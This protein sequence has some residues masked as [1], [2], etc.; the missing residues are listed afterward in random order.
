[1]KRHS[2]M[3]IEIHAH[4][5]CRGS[6][7]SK[8]KLS[9][10]RALSVVNYLEQHGIK[11]ARVQYKGLGSSQPKV[12]CPDCISCTEKQHALNRIFEFKVLHL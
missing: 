3:V 2:T 6:E 11:R 5:D 4:T 8:L 10:Q 1:L 12:Q 7:E 9:T